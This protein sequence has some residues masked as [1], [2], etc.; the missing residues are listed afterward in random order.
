MMEFKTAWVGAERGVIFPVPAEAF[1][2]VGNEL[3]DIY[4]RGVGGDVQA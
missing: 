1:G 2:Q 3:H 4:H